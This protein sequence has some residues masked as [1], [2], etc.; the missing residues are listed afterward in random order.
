MDIILKGKEP[1]LNMPYFGRQS[2]FFEFFN[3]CI[4]PLMSENGIYA[5]TNSGSVSNAY[6]FAKKGYKVIINDASIYSNAI[7]KSVLSDDEV[8]NIS[9]QND[10]LDNYRNTFIGRASVFAALI[11]L[12]G[13]NPKVPE[14]LTE[15]LKEKINFYEKHLTEIHNKNI[16]AYKIYN[17]DLFTYLKK[18]EE[19]N[20]VVDVM[21]MDFAWPWRDGTKTDE[22]DTTANTF[23]KII[24]KEAKEITIWDKNNV[25][26]NVIEAVN[27]AKKVSK[28]V[29]LSNQS[30]NYP[31]SE[32]LEVS[33]LKN[34][35][36]YLERH[37]MLTDA[38]YEDNL[39]KEAYFREYLYVIKG[40]N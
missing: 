14:K 19:E 3:K 18:L 20:I 40:N 9:I 33:L 28:Y 32:T 39:D 34:G 6:M 36:N 8:K 27:L 22:Y 7:A 2:R 16:R 1:E 30:S 26:N 35:I 24:N 13:Y 31:D 25:I 15:E 38:E 5:E 37:T 21:F 10:A 4:T 29:L 23:S 11:D 17:E 12:E